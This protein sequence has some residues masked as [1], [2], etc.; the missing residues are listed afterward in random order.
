MKIIKW[1]AAV[2]LAFAVIACCPCRKYKSAMIPFHGT[3]WQLAQ[4]QGEV[5]DAEGY[6]VIFA[7]DGSLSGTG[8]CNGFAGNY[9][10]NVHSIKIA[11]NGLVSTRMACPNQQREDKFFKM[12]TQIDSYSIDGLRLMLIRSGEV[13]AIFNPVGDYEVISPKKHKK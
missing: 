4:L 7:A 3:E 11:D 5:V 10:Q 13:L 6:K 9:T 12:L 1:F 2:S 8:D